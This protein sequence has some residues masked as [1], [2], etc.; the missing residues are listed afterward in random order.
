[1]RTCNAFGIPLVVFV[2][3]PGFLPGIEQEA[4]GVIRHGAKLLHAFAEASVPRFTV[5]IRKAFG[6]TY[7]TM[8]SK[9]LGA[10]LTLAWSC[11]Q[12]GIMGAHQ[13]VGIVNR[14]EIE[15]SATQRPRESAS[16]STTTSAT[17]GPRRSARGPHRRRHPPWRNTRANRARARDGRPHAE[18]GARGACETSR[19]E[20]GDIPLPV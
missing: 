13:A 2:D 11:A 17:S 12:L 1:V 3:T 10:D 8:N 6:G 9:D 4:I 14:R 16:P 15:Q 19:Y 5:V 18:R 7:I 20:S